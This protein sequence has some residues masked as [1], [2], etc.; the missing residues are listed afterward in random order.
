MIQVFGDKFV[1]IIYLHNQDRIAL[2]FMIS[3]LKHYHIKTKYAK[4]VLHIQVISLLP[5][6]ESP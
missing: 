4:I 2:L 1:Q 6:F 3:W 5:K